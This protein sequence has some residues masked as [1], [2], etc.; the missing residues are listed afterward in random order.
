MLKI[1]SRLSVFLDVS[2]WVSAAAVLIEHARILVFEQYRPGYGPLE[3]MFYFATGFG[4]IAVV[5]FF[6]LSGFLVGGEVLRSFQDRTFTWRIYAIKRFAR[7]YPV[8]LLALVVGGTFDWI[9]IHFANAGGAYSGSATFPGLD[10]SIVARLRP[11]VL[12]QNLVFLQGLT[13]TTFGSNQPL[14][15]LSYEAWYYLLFPLLLWPLLAV[16]RPLP[17]RAVALAA[18]VVVMVFIRGEM[19]MYF[20]VWLAGMLPHLAAERVRI[21]WAAAFSCLAF[22]L[23]LARLD[24]PAFPT[25]YLTYLLLAVSFALCICA[26]GKGGAGTFPGAALHSNLASFSYSLYACHWPMLVL[27]VTSSRTILSWGM[28]MKP[29]A[30]SYIF[31]IAL[32]ALGHIW[33][34]LFARCSERHTKRIRNTL[35]AV[36]G[37]EHTAQA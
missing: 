36:A 9:G 21:P 2:R 34:F 16:G 24:L 31:W 30:G 7:I 8:Y 25:T 11:S 14:W 13:S 32:V 37:R 15:S 23:L 20:L 3:K 1:S 28:R 17:A 10:F 26:V 18:A 33:A 27:A 22:F 12:G 29:S 35:L 6:V 4:R 5:I 19:L